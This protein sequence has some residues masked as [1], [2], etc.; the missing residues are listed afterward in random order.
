MAQ[1]GTAIQV[2]Q[3][4]PELWAS[5]IEQAAQAPI[6]VAASNGATFVLQ[7][8]SDYER[9]LADLDQAEARKGIEEGRRDKAAGRT[10]SVK[11]AFAEVRAKLGLPNQPLAVALCL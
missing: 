11:E 7:T 10:H 1:T 9:L 6:R 4:T 2:E 5:L 8:D 3:I